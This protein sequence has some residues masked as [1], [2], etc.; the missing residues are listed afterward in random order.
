MSGVREK[1]VL[2]RRI[3]STKA[4]RGAGLQEVDVTR[5]RGSRWGEH[6]L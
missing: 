4:L 6:W 1:S 5:S 2:A 3:T